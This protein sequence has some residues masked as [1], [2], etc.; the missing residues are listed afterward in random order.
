MYVQYSVEKTGQML[1]EAVIPVLANAIH[2][3]G[4]MLAD[5]VH[6]SR[7][8]VFDRDDAKTALM[9]ALAD[10]LILGT[11]DHTEDI[12]YPPLRPDQL[13]ADH[14]RAFFEVETP[15]TPQGELLDQVNAAIAADEA[16]R[17]PNQPAAPTSAAK[18]EGE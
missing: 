9:F 4:V 10:L 17:A 7:A 6:G 15:P 14:A 5:Q 12:Y 18:G 16:N 8:D 1:A 11:M 3:A 13:T 2:T